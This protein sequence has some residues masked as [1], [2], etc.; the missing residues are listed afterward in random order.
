MVPKRRDS[1]PHH[2]G[3]QAHLQERPVNG[4]FSYEGNAYL[5]VLLTCIRSQSVCVVL[6]LETA[7][8]MCT[9]NQDSTYVCN[10]VTE[11][12]FGKLCC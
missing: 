4:S 5:E 7:F 12:C 11:V 6:L 9:S 3:E 10:S 8:V 1:R 2:L